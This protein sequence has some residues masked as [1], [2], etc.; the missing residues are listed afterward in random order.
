MHFRMIGLQ[1]RGLSPPSSL[2]TRSSPGLPSLPLNSALSHGLLSHPSKVPVRM[3]A[4]WVGAAVLT[5]IG[6]PPVRDGF[7]PVI[8][9]TGN[10]KSCR[11][12][13]LLEV[14]PYAV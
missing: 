4:V 11:I 9:G 8:A 5:S 2:L 14:R 13:H 1:S 3:T 6:K 10:R 12:L 7:R